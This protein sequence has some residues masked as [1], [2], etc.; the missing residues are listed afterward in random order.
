MKSN[1]PYLCGVDWL[2][3]FCHCNPL[4]T[5]S[6]L[7][8]DVICEDYKTPQYKQRAL[9]YLLRDRKTPFAEI[10]FSPSLSVMDTRSC[11][12][13]ILNYWLYCSDW[14]NNLRLLVSEL[15]LRY[16]SIS[17]IDLYYDC[18]RFYNGRRPITLVRDYISQKVLKIGINRG[19]I[20]FEN[21]GY[22]IANTTQRDAIAVDVSLPNVNAITWGRKG[23]VQTQLYNKSL[24]LRQKNNKPYIVAA[25]ESVGLDPSDV[26]RTEIRIQKQGLSIQLLDSGDMWALSTDDVTN[27]ERI[28]ETFLAYAQKYMRFVVADYHRKKQQMQP[29]QLFSYSTEIQQ[30]IKPKIAPKREI[31]VRAVV[32]HRSFLRQLQ[33]AYDSGLMTSKD[34]YAWEKLGAAIKL[35]DEMALKFVVWLPEDSQQ[36]DK[37]PISAAVKSVVRRNLLVE[38]TLERIKLLNPNATPIQLAFWESIPQYVS[39]G[40]LLRRYE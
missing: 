33:T 14:Y 31:S 21:Y 34:P 9:C 32:A 38:D 18:N 17:R 36:R 10:L 23:Y 2:Q 12:V 4:V 19:S 5:G 11:H 7:H 15:A 37:M 29:I 26:W 13:R 27:N 16:K 35:V 22:A 28:Y 24:E 25:W 40:E 3:I 39:R 20:A 30:T 8:F 1:Y 6:T